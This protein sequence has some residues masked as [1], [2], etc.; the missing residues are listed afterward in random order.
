MAALHHPA[1]NPN[2]MWRVSLSALQLNHIG[3]IAVSGRVE[4]VTRSIFRCA[5]G[6]GDY[7]MGFKISDGSN[8]VKKVFLFARERHDL[9]DISAGCDIWIQGAKYYSDSRF[10]EEIRATLYYEGGGWDFTDPYQ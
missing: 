9:S 10:G 2:N 1:L 5:H 4:R 7:A 8:T 6:S 3:R